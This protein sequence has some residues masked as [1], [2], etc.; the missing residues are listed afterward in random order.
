MTQEESN[1]N[2]LILAAFLDKLPRKRFDYSHW[3]GENFKGKPD[4]S[5]GTTACALGWTVVIPKFKKMG[6]SAGPNSQNFFQLYGQ[7]VSA[8][9]I[10]TH[11]F[12]DDQY[13]HSINHLFY[14][15][16]SIYVN[17]GRLVAPGNNATP[18]QV[19]KHIRKFVSERKKETKA[20]RQE[21]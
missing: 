7:S 1:K 2:L 3:V 11:L 14:P 9:Q 6:V 15:Y 4:L 13:D 12:M 19:A 17:G 21:K 16:E 20:R 10:A 8:N 18:K 5:C